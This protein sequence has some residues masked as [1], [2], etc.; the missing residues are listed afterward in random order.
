M[1]GR[2]IGISPTLKKISGKADR[3]VRG[4]VIQTTANII[5][6]TPVDTGT[7][8]GNWQIGNEPAAP[9]GDLDKQDKQGSQALAEAK[10]TLKAIGLS[11]I[12]WITNGL[13]YIKRLEDG[14][15]KQ[16]GTGHMVKQAVAELKTFTGQIISQ[17]AK[18]G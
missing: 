5:R 4:I 3:L 18:G 14:W 8:R 1:P 13:P 7:A 6:R 2:I 12:I 10:A 16:S 9:G 15:S 11:G 17:I